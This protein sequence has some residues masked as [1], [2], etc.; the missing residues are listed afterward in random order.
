MSFEETRV[1]TMEAT[2]MGD[3]I[4]K[5]LKSNQT[6]WMSSSNQSTKN[7]HLLAG[8]DLSLA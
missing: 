4:A 1:V 8:S 5:A 2:M 6:Y 7:D 3:A